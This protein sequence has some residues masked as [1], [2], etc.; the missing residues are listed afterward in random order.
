MPQSQL[1]SLSGFAM[2]VEEL[3]AAVQE[4]QDTIAAL[5]EEVREKQEVQIQQVETPV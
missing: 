1:S 5:Q 4:D 3:Q 2:K